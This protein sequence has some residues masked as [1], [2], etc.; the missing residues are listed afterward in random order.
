M[1]SIFVHKKE[2]GVMEQNLD[3]V[4]NDMLADIED[5]LGSAIYVD[6]KFCKKVIRALLLERKRIAEL[7]VVNAQRGNDNMMVLAKYGQ[8]EA[9]ANKRIAELETELSNQCANYQRLANNS[10]NIIFEQE[11]KIAVLYERLASEKESS[12]LAIKALGDSVA[13]LEIVANV[14]LDEQRITCW[15]RN[16]TPEEIAAE[17]ERLRVIPS[18]SDSKIVKV[19]ITSVYRP[20]PIMPQPPEVE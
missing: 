16:P 3:E 12:E 14:P 15:A 19:H 20:D 9:E 4:G 2:G 18:P 10:A 6:P 1:N 5:K 17:A 11:D 7:E 13:E 8:L